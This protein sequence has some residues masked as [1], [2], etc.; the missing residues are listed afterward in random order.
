NAGD[1]AT[2]TAAWRELSDLIEGVGTG[3]G[4]P[5][6]EEQRSEVMEALFDAAKDRN[7]TAILKWLDLHRGEFD[8]PEPV[9][10]ASDGSDESQGEPETRAHSTMIGEL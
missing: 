9:V 4:E 7:V 1:S 10:T 2:A 6:I 5:S 8:Q 3:Q